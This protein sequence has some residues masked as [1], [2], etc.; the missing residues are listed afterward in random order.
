MRN[1][2]VS[3]LI[4][5]FLAFVQTTII[6]FNLVLL[7]VICLAVLLSPRSGLTWAFLA[8]L[9]LDLTSGQTLGFSSLIFLTIAFLINLY[10]S[11][12]KAAN[13]IYLLPFTLFSV[14]FYSQLKGEP[15]FLV[16]TFVTTVF[17]FVAWPAI[18][19]VIKREDED[20]LQLPLKI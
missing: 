5:I 19:L 6:P 9:I 16:N 2:I 20:S 11:K 3:F 8:G 10:K 13:F 17:L 7:V 12:F 15:L 18:N 1:T 4:I 14:W